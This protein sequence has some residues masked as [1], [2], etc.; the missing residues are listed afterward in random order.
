MPVTPPLV[1]T[2]DRVGAAAVSWPRWGE[3]DPPPVCLQASGP[4]STNLAAAANVVQTGP[5]PLAL[6][7]V[8]PC[9]KARLAFDEETSGPVADRPGDVARRPRQTVDAP[10]A[11][12]ISDRIE[13]DLVAGAVGKGCRFL[14]GACSYRRTGIHFAGTCARFLSG[15]CSY[16]RTGI[17]F[18]GTCARVLSGA[19]SYRRT[20][21]HFAGTCARSSGG[22]STLQAT[23]VSGPRGCR[24]SPCRAGR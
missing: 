12:A 4:G 17:H 6:Q 3:R 16:R 19:C 7:P 8:R 2:A 9:G 1:A 13:P 24:P 10:T 23:D 15:A 14:S 5:P 21:I 11:T 22:A 20:G 18:A